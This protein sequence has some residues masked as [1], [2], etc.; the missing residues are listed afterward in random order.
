[1]ALNTR[2]KRMT[3]LNI[4]CPWRGPLVDPTATGFDFFDR[5]AAIGFF[6][7][8]VILSVSRQVIANVNRRVS[9]LANLSARVSILHSQS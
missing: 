8:I 9:I 3:A 7:R 2:R 4:G 5:A 1:M 6:A